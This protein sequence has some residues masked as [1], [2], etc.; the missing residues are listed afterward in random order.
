MTN[1]NDGNGN[2]GGPRPGNPGGWPGSSTS[3]N[4]PMGGQSRTAGRLPE[5]SAR[6]RSGRTDPP[7]AGR[8]AGLDAGLDTGLNVG[9]GAAATPF[10]SV[11]PN[12]GTGPDSRRPASQGPTPV[13]IPEVALP[14]GG[15][16][17]QA[18][19]EKFSVNPATGAGSMSVGVAVPPG[20]GLSPEITVGYSTGAGN[21]PFGLGWSA[22]VPSVARKTD[23]G[24][25]RYRDAYDASSDDSDT[26]V[27]GGAE[28]L[29]P[30]MEP[31]PDG[32]WARKPPLW[33]PGELRFHYR[34]R[35]EGNFS[36]IE[37]VVIEGIS[38][39]E[40]TTKDNVTHV[41]GR[42]EL[43]RV[44]DPADD[45]RVF[46][47]L[48]EQTRDDLGNVVRYEYK[49]EDLDG[50]PQ[51]I[52]EAHRRA[53]RSPI[54]AR[55]YLKRIRYGNVH[56]LDPAAAVDPD[57]FHFEVVFDYGEHDLLTPTPAEI[58]PW[59]S[60]LDAFSSYRAGFELRTYRLCRRILVFHRFPE[61][62]A[63]APDNEALLVS[64]TDFTY[65]QRGDV[66]Y[67]VRTTQRGYAPDGTGGYTSEELPPADFT[68]SR[69]DTLSG[70]VQDLDPR[71]TRQ[72]AST[73]GGRSYQW[74]DLDGEGI[75]GALTQQGD[76]LYYGRNLG[77]GR[78]GP[79]RAL[80]LRPSGVRLEAGEAPTGSGG[81]QQLV[82]VTGDGRPDLVALDG[83]SPGFCARTPDGGFEPL[84][85]FDRLPQLAFRDPSLR[86]I[87]LTGDGTPDVV[88][89]EDHVYRWY[90]S[91][92]TQGFDDSAVASRF[93]DEREGP[94]VVFAEAEQT[95]FIADMTGDGLSDLVRVRNGSVVY[96]PNLGYGHFGAQVV[97]GADPDLGG[98]HMAPSEHY[99]PS[100]VRLA[101][102]DG[103]GAADL[104]YVGADGVSVWRNQAGNR[105]A[106]RETLA[107][108]P[109]HTSLHTVDLVDLLGSGTACLVWSTPLE[110]QCP[111]VRYVDLLDSTKPHLLVGTEN[112]LG[113]QTTLRYTTSTRMYLEDMQQGIAWFGRVPFPVHV[114]DRVEHYDH[115]TRHR[116]VSTYRYRH[117]HYD[118]Q[119]REFR[120]FGYVEQRDTEATGASL[121][122]GMLP[123]YPVSNDQMPLPPVVSKSWFHTGAWFDEHTLLER[124]QTEWFDRAS[125]SATDKSEPRLDAPRV[126]GGLTAHEQHQAHRALAG[127]LIRQEIYAEDGSEHADKP[128]VVS[129]QRHFV[130]R[131]Q[132]R[133]V[134]T[135]EG[136]A[137]AYGVFTRHP[138]ES[139]SIEYERDPEDP[140]IGHEL[141]LE[142]DALGYPVKTASAV[143]PREAPVEHPSQA[144]P[145][146]HA[147]VETLR[148]QRSDQGRYR[149]GT[150]IATQ[151]YELHD[152]VFGVG[153]LAPNAVLA[154]LDAAVEVAYD[155]PLVPG[156]KRLLGDT[157]VRYYDHGVPV[158]PGADPAALAFGEVPEQ[159]PL[160]V[161]AR[162][163]KAL[164]PAM[165]SGILQGRVDGADLSA[166][167]YLSAADLALHNAP[168]PAT[169]GGTIADDGS[170]WVWNG[171]AQFDEAAFYQVVRVTDPHGNEAT[172]GYDPHRLLAVTSTDPLGNTISASQIDYRVLAPG[173]VTDI[174]GHH[175]EA[176]YDSLGRVIRTAVIG[177]N[178]EG[179]SLADAAT[180]TS[181]IEY[182][183]HRWQQTQRPNRITTRVRETHQS[184][185]AAE[186][187]TRWL[188]QIAYAGGGGQ[189][190]MNKA[191]AAPGPAIALAP[192]GTPALV[193]DGTGAMVV[194]VVH[195]NPRWLASGRTVVD[196]KG[197]PIKQYE[198]YFSQT[199]EYEDDPTLVQWGVTPV[200]H[201][202][203]LGRLVRVD[204][205]DGTHAATVFSPWSQAVWD[206]NDTAKAGQLWY[207]AQYAQ[208]PGIEG[209]MANFVDTPTV[210]RL[211]TLGRPVS[212]VTHTREGG[213]DRFDETVM[214]LDIGGSVL[215][216]TD[217]MGR[218]C[219]LYA[220]DMLGQPLM[221]RSIDSGQR[222]MLATADG[223]PLK[224][225]GERLGTALTPITHRAEYDALRRLTH[226]WLDRADGGAELLVERLVYGEAHPSVPGAAAED[227]LDPDF[228]NARSL[229]GQLV[230][231]YDQSGAT[232]V[233]AFD[234]AGRA[235]GS[236]RRLAQSYDSDVDWAALAL[237]D[238]FDGSSPAATALLESEVFHQQF[239]YDALGRTT[240]ITAHDGTVTQPEYD[241][242]GQLSRVEALVQGSTPVIVVPFIEYDAHGRRTY[243][244]RSDTG[245]GASLATTYTYDPLS[246]RLTR[247]VTTR[248]GA[249]AA[250]LQDLRYTYDPVGNI[251]VVRDYAQSAVYYDNAVVSAHQTFEYDSLNR[252]VQAIGR[253]HVT[254]LPPAG[255]EPPQH[256]H[257][258][259]G[260]QMQLYTE[261]FT[262]DEVGNLLELQHSVPS[263][264]AASW[265]RTYTYDT[266]SNG[267]VGSNRLVSTEV[268]ATVIGYTHDAH[269]NLTQLPHLP[270]MDWDHAD[271]LRHVDKGGGGDAW[272]QYDAGGQRVRKVWEHG[273]YRDERIY[274]G[275]FEILRRRDAATGDIIEERQTVHLADDT[276][277]VCMV[278]TKMVE[279]GAPVG[280]VVPR[281]RYQLDNHLGTAAVEVDE[282]GEVISY[283]EYHP[284]GTTACR[285]ANA[286][287][288]V[289]PK[290]YRYTGKEKDEETGLY[291]HGARYYAPWLARWTAADPSGLVDGVNLYQYVRGNPVGLSDPDG[292]DSQNSA[293]VSPGERRAVFKSYRARLNALSSDLRRAREMAPRKDGQML[294]GPLESTEK[295]TRA[296]RGQLYD[297]S[298]TTERNTFNDRKWALRGTIE[299]LEGSLQP[300]Q[301]AI[302]LH[303]RNEA[304][305]A[306]HIHNS[307]INAFTKA[308][309]A[310]NRLTRS[311]Q[312]LR[313]LKKAIT[314]KK[315]QSIYDQFAQAVGIFM[316]YTFPYGLSSVHSMAFEEDINSGTLKTKSAEWLAKRLY[317]AASPTSYEFYKFGSAV[318][319]MS[320]KMLYKAYLD[321]EIIL[322]TYAKHRAQLIDLKLKL[323]QYN[324]AM[325]QLTTEAHQATVQA[326]KLYPT[327]WTPAT[328][329][330]QRMPQR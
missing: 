271:Q 290:R 52:W 330:P 28:D 41:Y 78:I 194:Q 50:V 111:Q 44:S 168:N 35:T 257:R 104:I 110:G 299:Q 66:T 103:T 3:A 193:D 205:P 285:A 159:G 93:G 188:T 191:S 67:L 222:W 33:S 77:G 64:S 200:M 241:Q 8:G 210:T 95:V 181:T 17:M 43:A 328:P 151:S 221:Q 289:S 199:D 231:H 47:W 149:H 85:R 129:Q 143:Y 325:Q 83:P 76:A 183:L 223:Q 206:A 123:S 178:G 277:R 72:L 42:S 281:Y 120:G 237:V 9:Q 156:T 19:A 22:A 216:V 310:R 69:A 126:P 226:S 225:W 267:G 165:L 293:I 133:A 298:K 18:I 57:H 167:G 251:T 147:S 176:M 137:P 284:Y 279:S 248:S 157:R 256:A 23:K 312:R 207:D 261:S 139:L 258:S 229:R 128:Y 197:N 268:G 94:T 79:A 39:W 158:P 100:R 166:G 5:G 141:V 246:F 142:V 40:V 320:V 198:P 238:D 305:Q 15:G 233:D 242:G 154:A 152:E 153:L 250:T 224:G 239:E 55:R 87:D 192:D 227:P 105:F 116:F 91:R 288:D 189:T 92:R 140:R 21:G 296:L 329:W 302:E 287:V 220:Y 2:P 56:G 84:R 113:L 148:H 97:M 144:K 326:K 112:N 186:Q 61:L 202:D 212:S 119:E 301:E 160:L 265:T 243:I 274:L 135:T 295:S 314:S 74:V 253:E 127:A 232:F 190:V 24:L 209:A 124:Y 59:P 184:A 161:Y 117:G 323:D 155:E 10:A 86:F 260:Q 311:A 54:G 294:D 80:D 319:K 317:K 150:P 36:R 102:I 245:G 122:V 303:R 146:I 89:S 163:A 218:D 170:Y 26:F 106:A 252:L 32:S 208:D 138:L 308:L 214:T 25:P 244:S 29:V 118:G 16:A 136:A 58:N 185:L 179:D 269:G 240:A 114:V 73:P 262:Y 266:T 175:A 187:T 7:G 6:P 318:Y 307:T 70:R 292:R 276:G 96:W 121:G 131:E 30:V 174:N 98:L 230:A 315:I 172:V 13:E 177:K 49:A 162:Y 228:P 255:T 37:R 249:N 65:E 107:V 130:R 280:V 173:R 259:D 51:E 321:R 236:T 169:P 322:D 316:S 171:T 203:P 211:D 101:D 82:D 14:K 125:H 134:P 48:L 283:E 235:T 34:P 27:L 132:P 99:D 45:H 254:T 68:Y 327:T 217:A 275:G 247:I 108:F 278:E 115:V 264:A 286:A 46:E 145:W 88:M 63:D 291:Y 109:G 60:R 309:I 304:R 282:A 20:R 219:M 204:M 300:Y 313:H 196:N 31:Q 201:Y 71:S 272:F 324:A 215:A 12:L 4:P 1:F 270:A 62:V 164:T 263:N 195:S 306:K 75:A 297:L 180:A 273:A 11:A 213:V 38:H 53:L 81:V 182:E 234:F 90:G